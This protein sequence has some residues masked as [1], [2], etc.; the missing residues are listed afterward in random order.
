M[1]AYISFGIS[2][3]HLLSASVMSAPAALAYAKLFY[4][5]TEESQ[6]KSENIVME[7]EY[8]FITYIY[9]YM[10]RSQEIYKL[11]PLSVCRIEGGKRRTR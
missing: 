7:T 4:P 3:S 10:T 6:T 2:A 1:A 11:A 9:I 5:E 8:S